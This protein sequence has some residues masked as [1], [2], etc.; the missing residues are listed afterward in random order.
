MI[1]N[2]IN[3]ANLAANRQV[4]CVQAQKLNWIREENVNVNKNNNN[5]NNNNNNN[6]NINSP[7]AIP[8]EN[9]AP[10]NATSNALKKRQQI[11]IVKCRWKD[12]KLKCNQTAH[13]LLCGSKTNCT[14][15]QPTCAAPQT[16]ST[17]Q[18]GFHAKPTKR[19]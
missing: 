19:G 10:M 8:H 9:V 4:V 2:R 17:A 1:T 11:A 18:K 14:A 7:R 3:C 13:D 16:K 15:D 12:L 6:N 5:K